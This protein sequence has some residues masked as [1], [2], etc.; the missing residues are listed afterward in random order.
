MET[1][2]KAKELTSDEFWNFS[3]YAYAKPKVKDQLLKLQNECQGNVNFALLCLW[4]D[5]LKLKLPESNFGALEKSLFP[6]TKLLILYRQSRRMAKAIISDKEY[7]QL[8]DIELTIEQ[9]QQRDLLHHLPKNELKPHD[10][11][12]NYAFYLSCLD[13]RLPE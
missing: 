13:E 7:Q 5:T 2:E 3:L 9:Q 6:T 12:H 1:I 8:Q 11:P 4:L 10:T